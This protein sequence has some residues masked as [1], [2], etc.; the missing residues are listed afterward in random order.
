MGLLSSR[1]R[2]GAVGGLFQWLQLE[3][4]VPRCQIVECFHRRSLRDGKEAPYLAGEAV[5]IGFE[6]VAR[7]IFFT[8]VG[9][10]WHHVGASFRQVSTTL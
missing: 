4:R 3:D 10:F 1:S 9:Q 2:S 5:K 8:A 7:N 6:K